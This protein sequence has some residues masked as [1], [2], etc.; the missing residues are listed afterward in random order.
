MLELIE[1]EGNS[2]MGL[3]GNEKFWISLNLPGFSSLE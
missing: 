1:G 2:T 3:I